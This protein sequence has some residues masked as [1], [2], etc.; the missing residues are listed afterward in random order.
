MMKNNDGFNVVVMLV[1]FG[2][3]MLL[4]VL[5]SY[6]GRPTTPTLLEETPLVTEEAELATEVAENIKYVYEPRTGLCFAVFCKSYG[7]RVVSEVPYEKV[8][9][10]LINPPETPPKAENKPPPPES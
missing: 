3:V 4:I 1:C 9:D 5:A 7:M 10:H 6:I 8:K 2:T